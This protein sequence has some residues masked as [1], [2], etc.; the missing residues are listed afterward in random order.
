MRAFKFFHGFRGG[1]P[2]AWLLTIVRNTVYSS[3][4]GKQRQPTLES[5]IEMERFED[6]TVNP[7]VLLER[8]ANIEAVRAAIAQLTPEFREVIVLREMENFSYK[9]I[10]DI[11]G[12]R[13][14]TVMSRLSRGRRELHRILAQSE[15]APG[16]AAL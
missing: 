11:T 15:T 13:V 16:E 12:V 7:T 5:D 9:E 4:R 14:G 3:L 8:A 2:R 1:D 6:L 10:A